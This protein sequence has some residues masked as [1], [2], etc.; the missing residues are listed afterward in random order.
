[1]ID[2]S[3]SV[4]YGARFCIIRAFFLTE[5]VRAWTLY[6]CHLSDPRLGTLNRKGSMGS[7]ERRADIKLS[8]MCVVWKNSATQVALWSTL[9]QALCLLLDRAH[10]DAKRMTRFRCSREVSSRVSLISRFWIQLLVVRP[11]LHATASGLAMTGRMKNCCFSRPRS[12]VPESLPTPK[13][14]V[15]LHHGVDPRDR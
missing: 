15:A 7:E 1:M 13:L 14:I 9:E 11:K 12:T 6:Y 2:A 4:C 5:F 8:K 3:R 10:I